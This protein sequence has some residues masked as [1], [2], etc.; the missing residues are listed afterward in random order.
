MF[1]QR[2]KYIAVHTLFILSATKYTKTNKKHLY[3]VDSTTAKA[4]RHKS[5]SRVEYR[6]DRSPTRRRQSALLTFYRYTNSHKLRPSVVNG[7][8]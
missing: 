2:A 5:E 6:P 8:S 1:S 3:S 7:R 4:R